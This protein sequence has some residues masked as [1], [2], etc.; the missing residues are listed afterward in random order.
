[1]TVL[2]T[3]TRIHSDDDRLVGRCE[4][5]DQTLHPV[6]GFDPDVALG[7]F[8][9]HHPNSDEAVHRPQ[10]PAGWRAAPADG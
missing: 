7:T 4:P 2:A 1:M 10:L 3:A 9:Q 8:F 6:E 5:C